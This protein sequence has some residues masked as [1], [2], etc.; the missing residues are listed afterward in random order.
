MYEDNFT[1]LRDLKEGDE[2]IDKANCVGI[3]LKS[4]GNDHHL[5][6]NDEGHEYEVPH[7]NFPI[8]K[9]IKQL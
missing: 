7:G 6:K 2:F 3:Y 4:L 5:L 8:F 1:R 9:K